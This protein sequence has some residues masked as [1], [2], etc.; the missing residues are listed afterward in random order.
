[1]GNSITEAS[2]KRLGDGLVLATLV[3]LVGIPI[4]PPAAAPRIANANPPTIAFGSADG[5]KLASGSV[6]PGETNTRGNA[7][8]TAASIQG[9][10]YSANALTQNGFT[11]V[12]AT[13]TNT[14]THS[15]TGNIWFVAYNSRSQ[16]V[17]ASFVQPTFPAGRQG[18]LFQVFSSALR[19][20]CYVVDVFVVIPGG[21]A[22]LLAPPV[23]VTICF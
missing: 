19:S 10:N 14:S 16:V 7:N 12:N 22:P 2:A 21:G 13:W 1:M 8:P 4:A 9:L 15:W 5:A 17:S 18:T 3:L 20:D 11:G 6:T 23:T